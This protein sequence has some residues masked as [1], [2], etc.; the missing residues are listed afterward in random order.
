VLTLIG[1]TGIAGSRVG[2]LEFLNEMTL[3]A[4]INDSL[5]LINPATAQATLIGGITSTR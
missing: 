3:Y 2:G 4:A 1:S 5:Y